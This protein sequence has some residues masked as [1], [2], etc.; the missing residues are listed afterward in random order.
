MLHFLGLILLVVGG[1]MFIPA[2]AALVLNESNLAP[3]FIVPGLGVM[4]LG[5]ALRKRFKP[6]A[7]TLGNLMAV[8]AAGWILAALFSAVPYVL[9][10]RGMTE[11]MSFG[12]AYF[13]SMAGY[14]TTGLSMIG[15]RVESMPRTV[16]FWRS[17]TQWVGGVGIGVM[18]LTALV[19][20]GK[21]A[22]KLY[23]AE[24]RV[25]RIEP[26]VRETAR[27]IWK[28]YAVLTLGS[29]LAFYFIGGM[30][31]FESTNHALT[32][33]STG[34]FTI[35]NDSFA[36][37]GGL[38]C[39]VAICIM[40]AGAISF[41]VYSKVL[42]GNWRELFGN[43]EVRLMLALFLFGM[44]FLLT[45]GLRDGAFQSASALTCTG[46]ST[47]RLVDWGGIQ[48]GTLVFFMIVGGGF[49]STAGGIK[50]IRTVII[51]KAL[52]WMVKRSFLPDRAVVPLKI[53]GHVYSDREVM[54]TA[55]YAFI[56][57]IVFALGATALAMLGP[58]SGVNA[59][60]E[61]ASAQGNV[62]LSAGITS[63]AMPAAGKAVL[64]LQML[65]GRLEII[66]VIALLGYLISRVPRPRARP[67]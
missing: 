38:V 14:T 11:P 20:W 23:I 40:L 29:V 67:F 63:A 54:E 21:A 49:G 66:P 58:Y 2:P 24:A 45:Q 8:V 57:I 41:A 37:Y 30:H 43:I 50:L 15:E 51:F 36:S 13:E 33:I 35:R 53:A 22:R 52:Y 56:Y 31:F 27:S 16:L 6:T 32:A 18:F 3:N 28:I 62:G 55:I 48:K 60:F 4:C 44:V 12:D 1:T 9:S 5:F 10:T 7:P 42:A 26:S 34:G 65:I 61:S 25:E 39:S 64:T 19:G 17:L 47:A 59:M 46:F